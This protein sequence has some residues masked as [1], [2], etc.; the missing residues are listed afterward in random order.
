MAAGVADAMDRKDRD[1][2]LGRWHTA[3]YGIACRAIARA[4]RAL[5]PATKEAE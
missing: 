5:N 3:D 2:N 1:D 4:I